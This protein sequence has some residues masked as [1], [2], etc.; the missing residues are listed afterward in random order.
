MNA[1]SKKS[2]NLPT[3][4]KWTTSKYGPRVDVKLHDMNTTLGIF[5]SDSKN[6]YVLVEA[7]PEAAIRGMD[8]LEMF[9]FRRGTQWFSLASINGAGEVRWTVDA[10][11]LASEERY[12][13]QCED[14][15]REMHGDGVEFLAAARHFNLIAK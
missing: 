12:E 11:R 4:F 13:E 15:G 3:I 9:L 5:W 14:E 2:S 6:S 10:N 7:T 1:T 8:W